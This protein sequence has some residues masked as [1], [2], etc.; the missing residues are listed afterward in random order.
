MKNTTSRD[1]P[2]TVAYRC[3]IILVLD[4]SHTMWGKGQLETA[5]FLQIFCGELAKKSRLS[6]AIDIAAVSMGDN[7]ISVFEK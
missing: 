7:K 5:N 4:T 2:N 6:N 1:I 3:P